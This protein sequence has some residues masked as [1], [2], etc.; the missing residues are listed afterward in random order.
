MDENNQKRFQKIV[1]KFLFYARAID[2]TMLMTIR[3]LVT[4]KTKPTIET[5]KENHSIYKLPRN[6]SRCSNRIQK[7]WND[8]THLL[9]CI[10]HIRTRGTKQTR[11][12]FF[13]G[14]KYN[15]PIQEIPLENGPVHVECSIIRNVMVSAMEA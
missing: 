10:L 2:P 4:V 11:R 14:P 7:K 13:L 12:K 3:S 6:T 9:G 5:A 15:T 8:S 1:G